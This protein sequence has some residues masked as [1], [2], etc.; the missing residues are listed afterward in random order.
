MEESARP[1]MVSLAGSLLTD[2]RAVVARQPQLA[3]HEM[4]PS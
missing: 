4:Q 1:A 3:K 2:I